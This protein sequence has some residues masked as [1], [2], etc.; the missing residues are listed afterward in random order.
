MSD[1]SFL[2]KHV[3]LCSVRDLVS[4][5][6]HGYQS[7]E[8]E[9]ISNILFGNLLSHKSDI[10]TRNTAEEYKTQSFETLFLN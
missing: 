5:N 3:F 8:Q 2:T 9:F 1:C 7:G 10:R 4:K 6:D